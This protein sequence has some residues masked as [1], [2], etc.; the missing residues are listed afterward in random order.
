MA[1]LIMNVLFSGI[2]CWFFVSSA[3]IDTGNA[4]SDE[5]NAQMTTANMEIEQALGSLKDQLLEHM[6]A[7][8]GIYKGYCKNDGTDCSGI[9]TT[10]V[11]EKTLHE[12]KTLIILA[13]RRGFFHSNCF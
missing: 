4:I 3:G 12:G 10:D 13:F 11:V 5:I 8:P 7:L 9:E 6:D 2:F 1:N